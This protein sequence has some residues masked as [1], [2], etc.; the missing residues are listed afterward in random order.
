MINWFFNLEMWKTWQEKFYGMLEDKCLT[1]AGLSRNTVSSVSAVQIL[2][3][4]EWP[5]EYISNKE[6]EWKQIELL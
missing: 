1:I 4:A 6:R 3:R 2:L 5:A